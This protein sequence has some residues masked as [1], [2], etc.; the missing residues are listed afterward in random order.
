MCRCC[1]YTA[2]RIA[3]AHRGDD[4]VLMRS[5]RTDQPAQLGFACCEARKRV[6]CEGI[7]LQHQCLAHATQLGRIGWR[8]R[9]VN[10]LSSG[11]S[12]SRAVTR[13]NSQTLIDRATLGPLS[14]SLVA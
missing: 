4:R 12:N 11:L 10:G 8:G 9:E 3:G 1:E 14:N 7:L 2:R 5:K 6:G 13:H